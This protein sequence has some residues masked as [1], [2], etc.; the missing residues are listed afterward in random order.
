[1]SKQKGDQNYA[2]NIF[3]SKKEFEKEHEFEK[4]VH[5][6]P[7]EE[8]KIISSSNFST[9]FISED[10]KSSARETPLSLE[11]IEVKE[12]KL[13]DKQLIQNKKAEEEK[14]DILAGLM[15]AHGV[16][17]V[18]IQKEEEVPE[19]VKKE[20]E[21]IDYSYDVTKQFYTQ[22]VLRPYDHHAERKEV[23]FQE[24]LKAQK[25]EQELLNKRKEDI[26]ESYDIF[27][28]F[29]SYQ[30]VE[31]PY[32]KHAKPAE[33]AKIDTPVKPVRVLTPIEDDVKTDKPKAAVSK[34]VKV[35]TPIEDD[36]KVEKPKAAASKPVKVLTPI[37][38]EVKAE[39]PKAASPK[40][41][42]KAVASNH[43]AKAAA[44]KSPAKT[45]TSKTA[46]SK[47]KKSLEIETDKSKDLAN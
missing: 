40:T 8:K 2:S 31:R 28:Q 19:S 25:K 37:E 7:E 16:T 27:S 33:T 44:A 23:S 43:P 42:A 39:K 34:P 17:P 13:S 29:T 47:A 21:E 6:E 20:E 38:D 10:F 22:P 4:Y 18:L 12:K 30:P 14:V 41:P 32:D 5:V 15:S 35:L 45:G 1:M 3:K 36:V 24:Q 11:Q 26:D 46:E 9:R